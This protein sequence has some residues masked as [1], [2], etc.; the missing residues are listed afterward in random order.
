M[1]YDVSPSKESSALFIC[2]ESYLYIFLEL[3]LRF[4]GEKVKKVRYEIFVIG[5]SAL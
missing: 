3:L 1:L 5:K 4:I 2:R